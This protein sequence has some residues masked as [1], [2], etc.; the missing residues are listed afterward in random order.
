M[1]IFG[2]IESWFK[3][4]FST[5]TWEQKAKAT[6]TVIAP[7][8]ETIVALSA[9][10]PAAATVASIIA[11][12]QSD[13][14]AAAALIGQAGSTPTL[15]SV[16]ESVKSNL[17]SLL[18]AGHIKNPE[19]QTKVTAAVNTIVGELEAVLSIVPAS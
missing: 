10:E 19:T 16:L 6:L 2:K 5:T 18:T 4:V 3:K 1:S 8:L 14:G 15:R 11:E 12:V 17:Q 13:L 9:G 7:L